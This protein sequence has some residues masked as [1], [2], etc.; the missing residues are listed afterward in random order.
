MNILLIGLPK[1]GKTTLLKTI[2]NKY[3]KKTGFFTNEIRENNI[4]TGFEIE[5]S[6]WNKWLF[7]S[8]TFD[9]PH[10]VGKYSVNIDTLE[11]IL[12]TISTFP[13]ED[14][15][16]ID[17][18]GPMELLSHTFENFC[19]NYLDAPN[20]CIATSQLSVNNFTEVI[21]QRSDI[22]IFE[23]TP[24][25]RDSKMIELIYTVDSLYLNK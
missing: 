8:T 6:K 7:A 20:L 1:A 12:P 3:S 21:H 10:K 14:I 22:I 23:I 24:E 2:L 13:S 4:R 15:L 18:I 16:F 9:T 11:R 19:M 17:E 25:N 5:T